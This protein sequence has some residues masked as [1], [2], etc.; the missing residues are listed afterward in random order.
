MTRRGRLSAQGRE[1]PGGNGRRRV[2]GLRREEVAWLAGISTTYYTKLERGKVAGIS[3][4]VLDGLVN[5]LQLSP[6]ESDYVASLI[7]VSGRAVGRGRDGDQGLPRGLGLVLDSMQT[8]PAHVLNESCDIVAA[9]AV[10]RALYPFHFE[11]PDVRPNSVRF[12]F[13]DARAHD[14]FVHWDRWA[15]QGVAYLRAAVA[16]HPHDDELGAFV[17]EL[18]SGS[19]E[20]SAMWSDHEAHFDAFG[21]RDLRHPEV[22]LLELDF[23]AFL[24]AGH[25]RYRMVTYTAPPGSPTAERIALLAG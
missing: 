10:G 4:A 7:R 19:P 20:F 2:A 15:M 5:A 18:R 8:I 14:F 16:R 12:L 17:A 22:G 9:N 13:L 25:R 6:E 11:N 1:L 24:I 21:I 23:Q 3:D